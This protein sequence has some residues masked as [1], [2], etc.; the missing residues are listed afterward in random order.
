M[1]LKVIYISGEGRSGSTLLDRIFGTLEGVSSFNEIYELWEH[2]YIDNGKCSCG[3]D[4]KECSFW[5]EVSKDVINKYGDPQQILKL[6][7]EVDHSRHF[8]KISPANSGWAVG[9]PPPN[10]TPPQDLR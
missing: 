6:Q 1:P 2:G 10:V 5:A 3:Q 7:D 4:I 9:S 8:L